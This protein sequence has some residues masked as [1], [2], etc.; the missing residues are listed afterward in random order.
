MGKPYPEEFKADVLA[1]YANNPAMPVSRICQDFGISEPAFYDWRKAAG[2]S[3]DTETNKA[4]STTLEE[5]RRV[6]KR[7]RELEQE[8]YILKR[9]TAYFAKDA[10]PKGNTLS[11]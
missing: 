9:A 10:L 4:T 11:S 7:N 5:L 6:Q 3:G 1:F 8:N 2:M